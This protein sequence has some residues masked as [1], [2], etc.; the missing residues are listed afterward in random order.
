VSSRETQ[1]VINRGSREEEGEKEGGREI[2]GVV[3]PR[4]P[5]FL[6]SD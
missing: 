1:Y 3:L 6:R 5:F 4:R 2:D